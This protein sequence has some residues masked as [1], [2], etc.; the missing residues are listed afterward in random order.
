MSSDLQNHWNKHLHF[1]P[2]K[3]SSLNNWLEESLSGEDAIGID[4]FQRVK[5]IG[6]LGNPASFTGTYMNYLAHEAIYYNYE[7]NSVFEEGVDYDTLSWNTLTAYLRVTGD[8]D[9]GNPLT[10]TFTVTS[11]M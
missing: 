9:L 8:A 10:V 7:H 1:I 5:Q 3:T 6:Y 11:K 4:R 2:Q